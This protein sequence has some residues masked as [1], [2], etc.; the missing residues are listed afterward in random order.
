MLEVDAPVRRRRVVV[1]DDQ[2]DFL[3]LIR[4]RLTRD[5]SLEVVG[6][7][8]SGEAALELVS[9]LT[10]TPDGILVD[11]EMPGID[12]FETA[13]RLRAL[14]PSLRVI[15]TSASDTPRYSVAASRVAALFLPKRNL[16]ANAVLH[17][18]D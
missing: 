16:S 10:P 17:L 14:A 8:A 5:Q 3:E 7:A 6:E 15:L 13:R 9:S 11:V 12:G 4:S 2:R 18:L 1:V